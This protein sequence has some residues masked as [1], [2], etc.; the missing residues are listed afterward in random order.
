MPLLQARNIV[1]RHKEIQAQVTELQ[2]EVDALE[3]DKEMLMSDRKKEIIEKYY[4]SG[5]INGNA[6]SETELDN[7]CRRFLMSEITATLTHRKKLE[8]KLSQYE[9]EVVAL[10]KR[11]ST[12]Q[13]HQ[14]QSQ[15]SVSISGPSRHLQVT[16]VPSPKHQQLTITKKER[17]ATRTRSQ[18]WPDVPDI[19]K[20]NEN[21]PEVLARKILETGRKI[22]AGKILRKG[23]E[24]G[25]RKSISSTVEVIQAKET[26]NQTNSSNPAPKLNFYEDRLKSIIT[27][28]L[29]EDNSTGNMNGSPN[30]NNSRVLCANQSNVVNMVKSV[31]PPLEPVQNQKKKNEISPDIA[32]G[33][34]KQKNF[35][36][37]TSPTKV[38]LRNHLTA[39]EQRAVRAINFQDVLH[40]KSNGRATIT[41]LIANDI[42]TS[43]GMGPTNLCKKQSSSPSSRV[44]YS[45]ISRPNSN[46]SSPEALLLSNPGRRPSVLVSANTNRSSKNDEPHNMNRGQKSSGGSDMMEMEGLAAGLK[47]NFMSMAKCSANSLER[48]NSNNNSNRNVIVNSNGNCGRMESSS[49][50][51]YRLTAPIVKGKKILETPSGGLTV[52]VVLGNSESSSTDGDRDRHEDNGSVL[53]VVRKRVG[54]SNVSGTTRYFF[55]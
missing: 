28:V 25:R 33:H 22:E 46:E 5:I 55:S 2:N 35:S 32:V 51:S 44:V 50:T 1:I 24:S 16:P 4:Q 31:T 12:L 3:R 7:M 52:E 39:S 30:G 14:Q 23:S 43:L 34:Q 42:E 6:L 40:H 53:R 54:D 17:T 37:V 18:E 20:I 10:E 49:S 26:P 13:Q 29:N 19:G 11:I 27:S 48:G 9:P 47:A 8:S 36:T 45:P 21:N 15:A 41:D 38:A